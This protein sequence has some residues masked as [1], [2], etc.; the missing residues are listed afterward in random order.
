[1][2]REVVFER[3]DTFDVTKTCVLF[4]TFEDTILE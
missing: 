4:K 3:V 1:L 2:H